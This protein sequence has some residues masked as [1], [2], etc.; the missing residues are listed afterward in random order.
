L[1]GVVGSLVISPSVQ[2]ADRALGGASSALMPRVAAP[3]SASAAAPA[4]SS[5]DVAVRPSPREQRPR[6]EPASGAAAAASTSKDAPGDPLSESRMLRRARRLLSSD[7]AASLAITREHRRRF[8]NGTLAQEREVLAIEAL[9]HMGKKD[10]A[11]DRA[12]AFRKSHP[13]SAHGD[14]VETSLQ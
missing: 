1:L 12:D 14:K 8:P 9:A 6:G 3:A 13:D 7:P 11:S 4:A 5:V 2:R 10:E